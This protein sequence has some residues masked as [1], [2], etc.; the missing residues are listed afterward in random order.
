MQ[1]SKAVVD[2][3]DFM[4]GTNRPYIFAYFGDHQG[5]MGLKDNDVKFN[6]FN[7][8]LYITGF[9]AKGSSEI[10]QINNDLMDLSELSLMPS[11]L[12]QLA[13]IKPNEF[14]K[15]NYAIRK[16]CKKSKI[17]KIKIF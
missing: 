8:P 14:F 17:A 5:N 1:L 11:V 16:I 3:N 4:L 7:E 15:A 9:Y 2:F 13:Q 12:L 6:N 10:K